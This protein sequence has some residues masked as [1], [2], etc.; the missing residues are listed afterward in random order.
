MKG[1]KKSKLP[2]P[3]LLMADME[4]DHIP[5]P[6][7]AELSSPSSRAIVSQGDESAPQFLFHTTASGLKYL[8]LFKP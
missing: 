7:D 6:S 2:A 8:Q 4:M 1:L 5:D 3:R